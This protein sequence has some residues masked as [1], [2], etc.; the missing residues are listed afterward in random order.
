MN[1]QYPDSTHINILPYFLYL[2]YLLNSAS[3]GFGGRDTLYL[4]SKLSTEKT[5]YVPFPSF[6]ISTSSLLN[7]AVSHAVYKHI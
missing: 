7:F 4:Y 6:H 3:E 5:S 1:T 2:P